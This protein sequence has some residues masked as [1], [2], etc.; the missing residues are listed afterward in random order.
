MPHND[1]CFVN[2]NCQTFTPMSNCNC[3]CNW[4]TCIE[5]DTKRPKA[6]HRLSP[7]LGAR[8]QNETKMFS[9]HNETSP[10]I[11][12]VQPKL[13]ETVSHTNGHLGLR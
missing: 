1:T 2:F 13:S 6:H 7:Y 9:D 10:L 3:N 11:A 4:G 8:R 12:A 5:P